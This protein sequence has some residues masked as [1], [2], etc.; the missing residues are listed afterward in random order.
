[1]YRSLMADHRS[2]LRVASIGERLIGFHAI[3]KVQPDI[4]LLKIAVTPEFQGTG[5]GV[6]LLD[7]V[8]GQAR[9]RGCSS[10]FLEVRASNNRAIRFYHKKGFE[11]VG[12]R[13]AYYRDPIEDAL[14][15]RKDFGISGEFRGHD[16]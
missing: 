3:T 10:C 4:E 9:T 2:E 5:V 13:R 14:V 15:M 11:V 8:F 6:A 12:V 1:M 7:D 16:I